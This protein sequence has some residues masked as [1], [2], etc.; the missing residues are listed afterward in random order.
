MK[1]FR[2]F[3]SSSARLARQKRSAFLPAPNDFSV[4]T[5]NSTVDGL[6]RY[7]IEFLET[8]MW[9]KDCLEA[10]RD[11]AESLKLVAKPWTPPKGSLRVKT[12]TVYDYDVTLP[13]PDARNVEASLEVKLD[14]FWPSTGL[15]DAQRNKFLILVGDL[16]DP[17]NNVVKLECKRFEFRAQN[18]KWLSDTLDKI[19]QESKVCPFTL[20]NRFRM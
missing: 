12:T 7:Q 8:A 17:Q 4:I 5:G 16:Y 1:Y 13:D 11:D 15:S 19:I 14:D 2:H 6:D 20:A 3:S 10:M 9:T 18:V